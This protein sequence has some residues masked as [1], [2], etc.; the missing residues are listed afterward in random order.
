MKTA[1]LVLLL[2][3]GPSVQSFSVE[4][5]RSFLGG[6]AT[7]V[8]ASIATSTIAPEVA[9][10]EYRLGDPNSVVGKEIRSFDALIKEFKNTALDGGLDASKID[11]LSM[12]FIEFGEFMKNG[13]VAE[14]EFMAP[15]GLEA[16]VTLKGKSGKVVSPKP[17]TK[18]ATTKPKPTEIIG[19][20]PAGVPIRIGQGYPTG[21][22]NSWSSPDYVIRSVSNYGVPYKFT[23]PALKSTKKK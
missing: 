8:G 15:S 11:G 19:K 14:V 7:V 1:I 3:L 21:A 10:A 9:F 18:P 20:Y 22:K 4:N 17:G 2:A 13:Q 16:Y 12:P 6:A 23:V 5:R